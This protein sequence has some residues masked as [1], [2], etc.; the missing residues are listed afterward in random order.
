MIKLKNGLNVSLIILVAFLLIGCAGDV[1]NEVESILTVLDKE[2]LGAETENLELIGLAYNERAGAINYQN[3]TDSPRYGDYYNYEEILEYYENY[4]TDHSDIQ[5]EIIY[6][7]IKIGKEETTIYRSG[8]L[9]HTP[10][11]GIEETVR[12]DPEIRTL[13]KID[14]EWQITFA[15]FNNPTPE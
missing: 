7:D 2:V 14:G 9:I 6:N 11:D 13:K 1:M 3:S 12:I 4:F 15:E 5:I 8:Y 10:I